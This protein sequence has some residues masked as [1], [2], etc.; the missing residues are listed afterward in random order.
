[1]LTAVAT[2]LAAVAAVASAV[3]AYK[4]NRT[5]DVMRGIEQ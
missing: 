2:A 1:M 5:A 3:A 4:A